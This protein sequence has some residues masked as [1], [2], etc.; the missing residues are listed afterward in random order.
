M[1]GC[2]VWEFIEGLEFFV[3]S[4]VIL[5]VNFVMFWFGDENSIFFMI[6]V[7]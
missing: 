4:I 5:L 7:G 1:V 2:F 6:L 3:D